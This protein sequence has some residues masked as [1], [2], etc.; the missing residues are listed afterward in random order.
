[1]ASQQTLSDVIFSQTFLQYSFNPNQEQH[2]MH[3]YAVI[4]SLYHTLLDIFFYGLLNMINYND[5]NGHFISYIL[6]PIVIV[7]NIMI[8]IADIFFI[9]DCILSDLI[10]F[11]HRNKMN[12]FKYSK[13]RIK[14]NEHISY[15]LYRK[16]SQNEIHECAIC[17]ESFD[18]KQNNISIIGCGHCF[19]SECI[20]KTE[21]SLNRYRGK[22]PKCRFD[23]VIENHRFKF[24]RQFDNLIFYRQEFCHNLANKAA[25]MRLNLFDKIQKQWRISV[26][27]IIKIIF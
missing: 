23:Y 13:S 26:L 3:R 11:F 6:R 9:K 8:I 21:K 5:M 1:M 2:Y 14:L 16:Y 19:H 25:K 15:E 10:E 22:C 27:I 4:R 18:Y 20:I 12:Y 24:N 17:L 7:F